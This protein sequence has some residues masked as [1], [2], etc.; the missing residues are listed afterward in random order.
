ML[1][2]LLKGKNPKALKLFFPGYNYYLFALFPFFI[3]ILN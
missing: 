1:A 3:Q 2:I